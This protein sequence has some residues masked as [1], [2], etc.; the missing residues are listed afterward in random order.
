M[1][2]PR[3]EVAD[4]FHRHGADWRRANAGHVSL[5]Q[6][7]VM[8]AIEQCRSAA[9]VGLQPTGLTRGGHVERCE[10]CGHSR[11]AYNSCRNR[12]CPKC[13]GAAAED[14]LAAREAD[15][16]PVGYFHVVF[17]LPAEIA[18][19]AYQNKAIVYD[20]LFRTAAETLLTIAPTGQARGLKAH[21]PK[22]LGARI[23]ATAVLHSWGSAMIHHPHVHMIVP[24]GGISLD[25][26]RW[27]RCKPG[28]LLP[29]RVLSRLFRR[30]FLA[31]LADAHAAG[32]LAFFG[33]I[34]GLLSSRGLRRASRAA[35]EEGL[36]RL[37]QAALR[38]TRSGARLSRPLHPSRRH[39]EQSPRCSRRA[40]RDLPVQ[41]LPPQRAGAVPHNDA[42]RRRVHQ[43]LLAPRSAEGVSSHPPL[44]AAGQRRLQGQHR[45]RQGADGR[46]NAGG[47]SA[48][49]ARRSRSGRHDR[50]SPAVPVLRRPH[51][52]CRGLWPR[53]RTARP[54]IG[55]RRDQ[56]LI[57]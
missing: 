47:R 18:P 12:H 21:D 3:L 55:R 15:L 19:I 7:Q 41:G 16:L 29:V 1:H 35:Q 39:L 52:H 36:V 48:G 26:T 14:W 53:R 49:S 24:G 38:R 44:R 2:R 50:S 32:R 5:G 42:Q 30:L 46:P 6:L 4:V 40:R 17:T 10:D 56:D 23:G 33:E 54:A 31:A 22:H 8:S 27:V 25:G 34:E 13:Q 45:T 51:D 57:R 9:L 20:L 28:F 11:I 43:A 37:R